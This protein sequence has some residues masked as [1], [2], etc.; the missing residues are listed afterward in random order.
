M[1]VARNEVGRYLKPMLEHTLSF[2]DD[3]FVFDDQSTDGSPDLAESLGA[4]VVRRADHI[5]SFEENEGAFRG[6]AWAAF[7]LAFEPTVDD[8][9]LV[10]DCDESLVSDVGTDYQSMRIAISELPKSD[11]YMLNIPEVFGFADET[12]LVRIDRLWGTI[13]VPRLFKYRPGATFFHGDFGVP[14]VPQYVMSSIWKAA[15]GLSLLHYGYARPEDRLTKYSRYRG[16][17]GHSVDHVNSIVAEDRQLVP[18]SGHFVDGM[19]TR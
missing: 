16:R 19:R 13:H 17:L 1:T 6:A 10:I 18:W 2:A 11:A 4:Y 3:C 5:P 7:E 12:P 9:V 15:D 8:L 14:A